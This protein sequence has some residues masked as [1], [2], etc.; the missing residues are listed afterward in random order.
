MKT[1]QIITNMSCNLRCT[2]CYEHLTTQK[3]DPNKIKE[4]LIAC[5]KRDQNK[6]DFFTVDFIGGEPFFVIDILEEVCE[7]IE[8]EY[9]N[10]GF[11]GYNLSFSTNA[12][13]LWRRK[14]KDFL[15]KFKDKINL[16]IS[17]DGDKEKHDLHRLTVDGKGS[18]DDCIKGYNMAYEILGRDKI[19][20][21]A[22]F[23]KDTIK[24]YARSVK[25]LMSLENKPRYIHAN[26]NF[27]EKFDEYDGV[28]IALELINIFEYMM[29]QPSEDWVDFLM[30]FEN[31]TIIN[32]V[33][34]LSNVKPKPLTENRCGS[35]S[36][37]MVS[38]GFDGKTYGC[39][40]FLSMKRD[41]M[42]IGKVE[43]A[44]LIEH[45]H[46]IK[47]EILGAYKQL[48]NQCQNCLFNRDCSDC[49]AIA[50]DENIPIKEYY[51][52][53]RQCGFTKAKHLIKDYANRLLHYRYNKIMKGE[54]NV[55]SNNLY[56]EIL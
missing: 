28:L 14:Q 39:N 1:Y 6:D 34:T 49:V 51:N 15:I 36:N 26:F 29:S 47:E 50:H 25:Y 13:L 18:F 11:K 5:W 45:T 33:P 41:G 8:Q 12:T 2:Y 43:N 52:Q 4:Y 46:S 55:N 54:I 30:L 9:R 17:I 53:Y 56:H 19:N 7:F 27:E 44:Q 37:H 48:P 38:L 22:T 40:R 42:D 20:I 16:G 10:Y 3:N 35:C 21:K 31:K 24:D 23:T 32:T